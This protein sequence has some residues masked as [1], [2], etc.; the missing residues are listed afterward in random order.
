MWEAFAMWA[1]R[2]NIYLPVALH[3]RAANYAMFKGISFS[4]L[5]RDMLEDKLPPDSKVKALEHQAEQLSME[6]EAAKARQAKYETEIC[7]LENSAIKQF[8]D[9]EY[10]GFL[11]PSILNWLIAQAG[12][13][14]IDL[15]VMAKRVEEAV[16][17]VPIPSVPY[18]A[19]GKTKAWKLPIKRIKKGA[20][21]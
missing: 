13:T 2:V 16:N 19:S 11:Y 3:D 1:K 6:I 14:G 4:R 21:F 18:H 17:K 5:I 15:D 20:M 12:R 7:Q 8:S 10:R 9:R